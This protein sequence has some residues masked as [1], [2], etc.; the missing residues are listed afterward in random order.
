MQSSRNQK[1]A[2]L[3]LIQ[4]TSH[5]EPGKAR[6]SFQEFE[7]KRKNRKGKDK[8]QCRMFELPVRK[9]QSWPNPFVWPS[10]PNNFQ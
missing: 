10:A 3:I 6:P 9:E 4:P 7:C 2:S 8:K 5:S 1:V